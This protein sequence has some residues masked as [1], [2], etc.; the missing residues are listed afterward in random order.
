MRR[1]TDPRRGCD[2][3]SVW[4]C[5]RTT[6]AKAATAAA[7]AATSMTGASMDDAEVPLPEVL[8]PEL[9]VEEEDDDDALF[10]LETTVEY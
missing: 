6:A 10:P 8:V 4:R 2:T 9:L 1:P 3:G 7:A 5:P